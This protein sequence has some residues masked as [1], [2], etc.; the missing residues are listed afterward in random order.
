MSEEQ[1]PV[2]AAPPPAP[3]AAEGGSAPAAPA[4]PAAPS[5]GAKV[6]LP[7]AVRVDIRT[8]V[9][10]A[11]V[12]RAEDAAKAVPEVPVEV[13]AARAAASDSISAKESLQVLRRGKWTSSTTS[14]RHSFPVRAGARQD[15]PAPHDR[16]LRTPPAL[17]GRSHQARPQHRVTA[18]RRQR[19]RR[20]GP[21][22]HRS[23]QG[24]V[25]QASACAA[26]SMRL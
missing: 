11:K 24:L 25:A 10:A 12:V 18:V 17:A 14:V 8:P 20:S 9:P 4:A 21:A 2:Q 26:S 5:H 16:R 23:P 6:A 19:R 1:K 7:L 13:Q 15:S 3:A 22:R